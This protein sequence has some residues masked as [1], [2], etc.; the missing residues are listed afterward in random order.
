MVQPVLSGA[1]GLRRPPHSTK[2]RQRL[3]APRDCARF[4]T[5]GYI[6]SRGADKVRPVKPVEVA[7]AGRIRRGQAARSF[8]FLVELFLGHRLLRDLGQL[9][10][11]VDHLFLVDRRPDARE[12][13]GILLVEVPHFL[14][15]PGILPHPLHQ[16]ARHFVVGHLD[17]VL[18][19]DFRKDEAEPDPPVGDVAVLGAGF[20]LGRPLV[21][22]GA[23]LRLEVGKRPY[24]RRS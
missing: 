11:E 13:I 5:S 1:P 17:V 15:A 21:L 7:A 18:L 2:S 3:M 19:A 14:L 8:V 23:V 10:Q 4:S 20:L 9:D 6:G 22:E 24:S 12:R 16:R